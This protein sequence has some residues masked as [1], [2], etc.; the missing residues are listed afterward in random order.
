MEGSMLAGLTISNA[1][2]TAVHAVS[3]P[4]TVFYGVPHG[5][6]CSFLLPAMIRFNS[7]AI[8]PDKEQRLLENLGAVS[9]GHM[10]ESVE[11]LQSKLELPGRLSD[12]GIGSGEI[13][14]IV[15][16]G[17]RPDRMANN[18]K[19]IC[20]DQLTTMLEGII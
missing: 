10:A 7:E 8:A 20:A 1:Q 18:P 3:Y 19:V 14:K 11:L 2:T 16:N 4:I 17:Y 6:A 12:V 9:M 5:L 13:S 15:D